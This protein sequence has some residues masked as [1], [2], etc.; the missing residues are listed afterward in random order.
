MR[1]DINEFL[2]K[3]RTVLYSKYRR[4]GVEFPSKQTNFSAL[5]HGTESTYGIFDKNYC[6]IS[7]FHGEKLHV[8]E[9]TPKDTLESIREN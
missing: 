4:L 1:Q 8:T 5:S 6:L 7:V 3:G 9:S 2:S